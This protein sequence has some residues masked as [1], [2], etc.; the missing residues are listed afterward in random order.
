M[1]DFTAVGLYI[2]KQ[3]SEKDFKNQFCL[4]LFAVRGRI[5]ENG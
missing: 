4:T 3:S 5:K 1:K 2:I